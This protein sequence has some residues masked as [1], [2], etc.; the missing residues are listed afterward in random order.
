M[1]NYQR[2]VQVEGHER[3]AASTYR[4][5]D[6]VCLATSLRNSSGAKIPSPV[7]F[8][9]GPA[10]PFWLPFW[11][12]GMKHILL[13]G[14]AITTLKNHGVRQWEGWHPI[15]S[16]D[17]FRGK[18]T[19]QE[20]NIFNVKTMV[21]CKFSLKPSHGYMKWEIK[22]MFQTTNHFGW[23]CGCHPSR[24]AACAITAP[25]GWL[26]AGMDGLGSAEP[27]ILDRQMKIVRMHMNNYCYSVYIYIYIW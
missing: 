14:G 27:E 18:F 21:S 23:S 19:L 13:V 25:L 16:M 26:P 7:R 11:V 8:S 2:V 9:I 17:W 24:V 20:K 12:G 22:V 4:A 3:S 6:M 5:G 10:Y 15:Y 1:L